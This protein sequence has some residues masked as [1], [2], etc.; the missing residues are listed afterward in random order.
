MKIFMTISN[1]N[2]IER[3]RIR[4]GDTMLERFRTEWIPKENVYFE[5]YRI[6]ENS[7]LI[8]S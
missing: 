1:D 3:I 5:N 7:I 2:Q 6:R 4:N 8:E